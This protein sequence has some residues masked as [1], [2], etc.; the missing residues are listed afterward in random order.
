MRLFACFPGYGGARHN[1]M[2]LLKLMKEHEPFKAVYPF[3]PRTSLLAHAFNHGYAQAL[4]MRKTHGISHFLLMHSDIVPMEPGWL[5]TLAAE[6]EAHDARVMSVIAPIKDQRGLTSTALDLNDEWSPTRLTMKQVMKMA[7]TFTHEKLLL[8]TGL[9]LL[10]L[11]QAEWAEQVFFT[12]RDGMGISEDRKKFLPVVE[13]EDWYF[14]RQLNAL[15][16]K[17]WA[18]RKV[19]IVHKGDFNYPNFGEWG[20]WDEDQG[21]AQA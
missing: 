4:M 3:E 17:L 14:S 9:L 15:G 21:D 19:K 18:T 11:R 20:A 7:E 8:N 6:M 12:I 2:P 13:P 5:A 16:V 10:D 1:L